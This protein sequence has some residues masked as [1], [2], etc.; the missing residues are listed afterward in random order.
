MNPV[1]FFLAVIF[2]AFLFPIFKGIADDCFYKA[3]IVPKVGPVVSNLP[4]VDRVF[5]VFL[6]TLMILIFM[7]LCIALLYVGTQP[8]EFF[9]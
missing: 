3:G 4:V 6:G 7:A 2:I 8:K 5:N 9:Q 1:A